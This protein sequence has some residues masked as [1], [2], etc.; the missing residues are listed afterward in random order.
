MS[1]VIFKAE[2]CVSCAF[3]LLHAASTMSQE[4]FHISKKSKSCFLL[5]IHSGDEGP[6]LFVFVSDF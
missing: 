6:I 3:I 4:I 2:S 5:T 1:L